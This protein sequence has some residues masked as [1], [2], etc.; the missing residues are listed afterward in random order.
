MSVFGNLDTQKIER[1][2]KEV[3]PTVETII[4]TFEVVLGMG[5]ISFINKGSV[6]SLRLIFR[7]DTNTNIRLWSVMLTTYK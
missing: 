4:V 1:N 7:H 3:T 2:I 5:L 6:L